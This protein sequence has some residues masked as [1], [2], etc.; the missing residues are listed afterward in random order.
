M[1]SLPCVRVALAVTFAA[2]AGAVACQPAP[3]L[4]SP[5]PPGYAEYM[6][7]AQEHDQRA[8]HNAE[9]APGPD[10]LRGDSSAMACS[11]L[12]L[13]D[14]LTGGFGPPLATFQPCVDVTQEA[15]RKHHALAAREAEAARRDRA[16]A[17]RLAR[18]EAVACYGIP[19][20]ERSRSVFAQRAAIAD[21]VPHYEAGD[22]HGVWVVFKPEL[23]R[24]ADR[25]RRD[26]DCTR[27]RSEVLGGRVAAQPID[28]TL[29]PGADVRVMQRK[30]HVEV[31]VTTASR[32]D[33]ALALARARG[34]VAAN[35]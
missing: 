7:S 30:D 11:D 23:G 22:L 4:P 17:A 1:H 2:S 35:N 31:L 14:Q 16:M 29:V 21:V 8:M 24:D 10:A 28:P 3:Q 18:V 25:V 20:Q 32:P 34:Q 15:A 19:S 27:A 9:L 12:V 6:L 26:I 13:N 5:Y 33:A